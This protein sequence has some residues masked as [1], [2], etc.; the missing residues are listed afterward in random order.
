MQEFLGRSLQERSVVISQEEPLSGVVQERPVAVSQG[1]P[2]GDV[3]QE[4]IVPG[5]YIRLP[6]VSVCEPYRTYFEGYQFPSEL[7]EPTAREVARML[8]QYWAYIV[9]ENLF[10]RN[11]CPP[12]RF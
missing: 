9:Q 10:V 1:E 6:G 3:V 7:L 4:S 2:S 5:T 11:P 12:L 8:E